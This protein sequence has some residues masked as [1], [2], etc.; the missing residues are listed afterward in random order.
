MKEETLTL[1]NLPETLREVLEY[2]RG[3]GGE[4]LRCAWA[5]VDLMAIPK[6]FLPSTTVVDIG[7]EMTDNR[8]RYWGSKMTRIHGSDMTGKSPFDIDPKEMA[9]AICESHADIIKNPRWTAHAYEF[10]RAS[11]VEHR[12]VTLRMPLSDDGKTVSQIVTVIDLSEADPSDK[13]GLLSG[14]PD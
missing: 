9:E 2:W 8:Y 3:L 5:Q 4:D 14:F 10:I 12:H 11:G 13:K 1:E 6:Q 7:A